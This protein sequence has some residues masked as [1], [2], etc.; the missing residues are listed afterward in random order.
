[1]DITEFMHEVHNTAIDHGW[2]NTDRNFG[3]MIALMHTELSEAFEEYRNGH[4]YT[5]I[6]MEDGKP[7]G[8]P[9][10]LADVIIRILDFC[11]RHEID[12]ALALRM[13]ANYNDSRPYR[14]GGKLA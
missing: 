5:Q 6:Y 10:E 13:K 8:V 11:G 1:M 7:E 2:W 3:E 4:P 9:I 14:H 12:I